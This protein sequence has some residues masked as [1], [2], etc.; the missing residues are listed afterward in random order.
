MHHGASPTLT[1]TL[2]LSPE[3]EAWL[4]A[5]PRER[6]KRLGQYMTPRALREELLDRCDLR[7]GMRVLD[8]G[9]GT[10][11]FLRSVADRVADADLHGWDVDPEVLTVASRL[12]PEARLTERSA[13]DPF[14]GSLFDLVIGNPPYFQFR[15]DRATRRDFAAV[16]SGRPN[17]FALFFQASI[18]LLRPGG[19]LAFVVP[20]SMNNGAY[21]DGL[22]KFLLEH[23]AIEYLKVHADDHFADAQT[24]VQ[25]LV[26]RRGIKD[27]GKHVF[28][29]P[30]FSRTLF[31]EDPKQLR[32]AFEGRQT[33]HELGYEAVTGTIVWNQH[34]EEL[35]RKP[36][37]RSEPLIWAH[38]IRDELTVDPSHRRPAY[39]E[40]TR[41]PLE[42]PAIV[43]N[44]I[45]GAV[46]AG[47]IRCAA[48]PE[49]FRFLAENHVNVIRQHGYF[50]PTTTWSGLLD[51]LRS[52]EAVSRIRLLTGNTQISATELSH[53]L[54]V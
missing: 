20:P 40:T 39:I 15:A 24:P 54:P 23:S 17:I 10:G 9:V 22:R 49:G 41:T 18:Q 33:L 52:P 31:A 6:R 50:A 35:R 14:S 44:R 47:Q 53:L 46:G 5:A 1:H 21:F 34:R 16:I 8:P 27:S 12:V 3:T 32:A 28:R 19:Q 26:L 48:V 45:V 42:G 36:T 38:C 43:V 30:S 13:L 7:Q 37:T 25:L 29:S 4:E 51:R 2:Q 11:E